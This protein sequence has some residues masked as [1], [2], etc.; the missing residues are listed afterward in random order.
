M[1]RATYVKTPV[2]SLGTRPAGAFGTRTMRASSAS[3]PQ[4]SASRRPDDISRILRTM[5]RRVAIGGAGVTGLVARRELSRPW[6]PVEPYNACPD[7]AGN[8]TPLR[9]RPAL[10]PYATYHPS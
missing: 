3:A 2:S 4:T 8:A 5:P 9:G 10:G 1:S 6:L 7:A